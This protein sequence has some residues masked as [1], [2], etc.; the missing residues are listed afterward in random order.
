MEA[1]GVGGDRSVLECERSEFEG[2]WT[3]WLDGPRAGWAKEKAGG[4]GNGE[5][6][7]VME[8]EGF[9]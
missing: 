8:G 1:F 6:V 5:K 4:S 7:G 2:G 3:T 9:I